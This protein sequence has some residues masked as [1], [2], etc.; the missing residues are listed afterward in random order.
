MFDGVCCVLIVVVGMVFVVCFCD[1]VIC[2]GSL[3]F[4]V[5]FVSCLFWAVG[6]CVVFAL[7]YLVFV[8]GFSVDGCCLLLARVCRCLM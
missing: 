5:L 6:S 2:V 7:C 1:F 8:V 4:A 3:L